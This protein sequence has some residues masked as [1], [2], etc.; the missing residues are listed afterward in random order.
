MALALVVVA[1]IYL[2]YDF[3]APIEARIW[4][5]RHGTV[6]TVGNYSVPV[7][8]SW[9]VED[10]GDGQQIL[11]NLH[12][13]DQTPLKRMKTHASIVLWPGTPVPIESLNRLTSLNADWLRKRGAE[14]D[15]QRTFNLDGDIL[16]CTGG[17]KLD[18]GRIPDF[19]P[20]GWHCKLPEGLEVLIVATDPDLKQVWDIV[21]GIRRK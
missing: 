2:A 4:H 6:T 13:N 10:W 18:S 11:M 16:L 20:T 3:R 15:L 19:E 1:A 17:K 12:T 14:P 21:S 8:A 9:Y 7:P 5:L